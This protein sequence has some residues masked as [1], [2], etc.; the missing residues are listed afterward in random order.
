[1]IIGRVH[2]YYQI[3]S[4]RLRCATL[5]LGR[6]ADAYIHKYINFYGYDASIEYTLKSQTQRNYNKEHKK[7]IIEYLLCILKVENGSV[8]KC[9]WKQAI[10]LLLFI[11]EYLLGDHGWVG[12]FQESFFLLYAESLFTE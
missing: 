7:I 8:I 5:I 12:F 9:L 11:N 1:M 6:I 10:T 4:R 2:R 3:L